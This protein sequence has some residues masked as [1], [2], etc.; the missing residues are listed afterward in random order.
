MDELC[1]M[2]ISP[3]RGNRQLAEGIVDGYIQQGINIPVL[4]GILFFLY[5]YPGYE[6]YEVVIDTERVETKIEAFLHDFYG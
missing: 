1:Q 5:S 3:D 2:L 4:V 6:G